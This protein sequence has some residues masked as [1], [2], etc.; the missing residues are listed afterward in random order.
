[1]A[2]RFQATFDCTDPDRIA[3]FWAAALDYQLQ[4]PPTGYASWEAFLA[5]QGIPEEEWSRASAIVDPS[6][7]GPRLY[8]QRVPE[9]KVVKNRVHLDLD[10]GGGPG[11]PQQERATRVDAA[12]ERLIGQG[13][14]RLRVQDDHGAYTVVMQ[15]PE[16]NE[17]CLH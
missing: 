14:T 10:V 5:A 1:M 13:A 3:R 15:D 2:T 8:F 7:Q 6:G 17:F 11:S 16:D 9:P 4:D 12:V